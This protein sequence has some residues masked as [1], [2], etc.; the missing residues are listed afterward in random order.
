MSTETVPYA[1]ARAR[2]SSISGRSGASPMPP[3]TIST[4]LPAGG[5]CQAVPYGP[6]VPIQSPRSARHSASLTL[7]TA[8]TVWESVSPVMP[9]VESGISP[10]PKAYTM[11]Y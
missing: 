5:V 4:S 7:P 1:S 6:L 9:L 8:R 2:T 3:A 10:V 11:A